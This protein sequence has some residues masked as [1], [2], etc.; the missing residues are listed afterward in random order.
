MDI[1]KAFIS[2]EETCNINIIGTYD[3]PLFQANQVAKI[4]GI[5]NIRTSIVNFEEDEKVVR[6]TVTG[7]GS[8]DVL[9][10][11]EIGLYRLLGMSRKPIAKKFQKWVANIIKEIRINGKYKLECQLKD[12]IEKS[13]N[14]NDIFRHKNILK[15]FDDKPGVYIGKIKKLE[16]DKIIIKIGSSHA[17]DKRSTDLKKFFGNFNLIDF[18]PANRYRAFERSI[19]NDPNVN[20]YK[21][22]EEINGNTSTETYC[23]TNEFYSELVSIINRKQKDYQG[24][25]EEHLFEI[26]KQKKELEILEKKKEVELLA[27]QKL[28]MQNNIPITIIKEV[29]LKYNINENLVIKG[30]KIQKYT[31]EGQL[32]IT[33]N[34]LCNAARK[35]GKVSESGIRKAINNKTIYKDHRWLYLDRDLPDDTVQD[36]GETKIIKNI[37]LGFIAMLD[38]NKQNIVHVFKNQLEAATSR[39]LKSTNCI[40]KSIK[41]GTLCSGH[42]FYLWDK[43]NEEMKE[44]YLENNTL[45]E[46]DR[47]HNA[48]KV[49]QIHPITNEVVKVFLSYTDI[50][51]DYQVSLRKIKQ[52]MNNNEIYKGY[53]WQLVAN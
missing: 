2:N 20:K 9:F 24:M 34:T 35:E 10:L 13:S 45:P 14:D 1:V 17:L 33:Y 29:P 46:S 16:N 39:H 42:Y 32:V 11:T 25:S 30:N 7:G 38:I 44:K 48:I 53:K 6:T 21:Y 22:I 3:E 19:H 26:E 4:L 37:N 36:L 49:N 31:S 27:L 40:Y 47:R 5:V 50:M 23:V 41:H 52:V 18:F 15:S 8:Q 43:C 12:V 28:Q 51:H